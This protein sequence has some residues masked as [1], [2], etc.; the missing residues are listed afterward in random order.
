MTLRSKEI[1]SECREISNTRIINCGS[2]HVRLRVENSSLYAIE[3]IDIDCQFEDK[4]LPKCD[5]LLQAAEFGQLFI[6]LKSG[7]NLSKGWKQIKAT[8][9]ALRDSTR[10]RIANAMIV[11]NRFDNASKCG[12][13]IQLINKEIKQIHHGSLYKRKSEQPFNL[14]ELVNK[15]KVS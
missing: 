8:M 1:K 12:N 13:I 6:E 10:F 2:K 3:K 11:S 5:F 9:E 4:L 14:D 7:G 15:T